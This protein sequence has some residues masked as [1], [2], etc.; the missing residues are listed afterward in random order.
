MATLKQ[1]NY[2]FFKV[3]KIIRQRRDNLVLKEVAFYAIFSN[4]VKDR[5]IQILQLY[6]M[7]WKSVE[8]QNIPITV[9]YLEMIA[10]IVPFS[11]NENIPNPQLECRNLWFL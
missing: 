1:E 4:I 7:Y 6:C 2:H 10:E 3:V 9:K 8:Q 11:Q 5:L